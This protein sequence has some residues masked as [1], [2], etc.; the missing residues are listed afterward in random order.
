MWEE[1][2]RYIFNNYDE[3]LKNVSRLIKKYDE[4]M[5]CCTSFTG[6]VRNY[7]LKE[8]NIIPTEE[9]IIEIDGLYEA[10]SEIR[11]KALKKYG[12]LD[13]I[14]YHNSGCLKVGEIISSYHIFAKHRQEAFLAMEYII[15]EIKK[16]H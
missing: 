7:H 14:I 3:Y 8:G 15:N 12:L 6:F 9:M 5:G 1:N 13:V 4:E 16:Y 10:L 2:M 11:K